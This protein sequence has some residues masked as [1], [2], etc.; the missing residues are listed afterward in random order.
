MKQ[1]GDTASIRTVR[2]DGSFEWRNR[3]GKLHCEDGPA[4]AWPAKGG[5]ACIA[6]ASF[7][8]KTAP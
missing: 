4:K 7:T 1:D 8:G 5:K 6:T 2:P 3:E